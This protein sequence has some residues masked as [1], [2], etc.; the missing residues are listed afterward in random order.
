MSGLAQGWCSKLQRLD[1]SVPAHS[2]KRGLGDLVLDAGSVAGGGV[3][4]ES[5]HCSVVG[6]LQT[7][8]VGVRRFGVLD[9]RQLGGGRSPQTSVLDACGVHGGLPAVEHG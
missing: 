9:I 8:C 4:L 6:L 5:G 1:C 2:M 3:V 7:S